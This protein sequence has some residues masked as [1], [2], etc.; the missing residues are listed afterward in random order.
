MKKPNTG[1]ANKGIITFFKTP[2]HSTTSRKPAK[3]IEAPIN[4]PIK[5]VG[6]SC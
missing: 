6:G 3:A 2:T 4:P 5:G 1:E